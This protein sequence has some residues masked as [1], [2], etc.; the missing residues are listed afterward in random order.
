MRV[1]IIKSNGNIDNR[2]ER[3][4][5]QNKIKGDFIH[6]F[7]RNVINQYDVLIMTYQNNIPN[8]SKIIES[9]VLEQKTLILF[10]HNTL[11]VGQFYNVLYDRYFN[12]VN[13]QFLDIELPNFI[14]LA[15]KYLMEINRLKNENSDLSK[16]LNAIKTA[17]FAKRIL[18]EKGY[19]EDDSHKFIQ[20]KAM[21]LRKPRQ[22]IVNLIIENKID[23]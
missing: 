8:I 23:F 19:S 13:E 21:D 11:S 6:K 20:K 1:G 10:I 17:N 4:L 15:C 22:M 14:H 7:S 18:M 12:V 16:Q 2:I 5:V 9:I 3:V